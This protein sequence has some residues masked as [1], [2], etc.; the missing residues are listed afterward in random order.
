MHVRAMMWLGGQYT[1]KRVKVVVLA[2]WV[3]LLA[4][5]VYGTSQ[6]KVDASVDT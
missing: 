1:K 2:A 6:M 3:A 4:A 5:G